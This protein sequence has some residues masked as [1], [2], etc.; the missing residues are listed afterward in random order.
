MAW[1]RSYRPS[2]NGRKKRKN[3]DG[4]GASIH[5]F[6]SWKR[7]DNRITIVKVSKLHFIFLIVLIGSIPFLALAQNNKRMDFYIIENPLALKILNKYEQSLSEREAELFK[8]FCALKIINVRQVLS[9]NFTTAA[10]VWL[11]G[12]NFYLSKDADQNL[13]KTAAPGYFRE[14]KQVPAILDT[15][16]IN[17]NKTVYFQLPAGHEKNY[18]AQGTPVE[19]IFRF[20]DQIYVH[21]LD[22]SGRYGWANLTEKSFWHKQPVKSTLPD[23][24]KIYKQIQ[25]TFNRYNAR[26]EQLFLYFNQKTRSNRPVPAWQTVLR[27][28]SIIA[29]LVNAESDYSFRHSQPYLINELERIV[30]NSGLDVSIKDN[31]IEIN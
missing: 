19:R 21:I 20:N 23:L 17:N 4:S 30:L 10:Q 25:I 5:N 28:H 12:N 6:I 27:N 2:K 31:R 14:I 16:V 15:V 1:L 8:P 7:G 29:T 3:R 22:G 11:E 26:Y 13:I 18:L 9:D 24:P